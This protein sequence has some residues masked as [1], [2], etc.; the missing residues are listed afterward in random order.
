M[1]KCLKYNKAKFKDYGIW[2]GMKQTLFFWAME[3]EFLSH[4]TQNQP[5]IL[6]TWLDM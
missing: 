4:E 5:F 6:C 2:K 3:V 1:I